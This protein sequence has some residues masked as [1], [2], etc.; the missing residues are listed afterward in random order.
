MSAT[1]SAIDVRGYLSARSNIPYTKY[2][3]LCS[4]EN[5][6]LYNYVSLM[7]ENYKFADK[8]TAHSFFF[9]ALQSNINNLC[10]SQEIRDIAQKLI[11]N[12]KVSIINIINKM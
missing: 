12:K 7:I 4:Y 8:D 9:L 11:N 1:T 3:E 10:M 6:S 5:W 2:F